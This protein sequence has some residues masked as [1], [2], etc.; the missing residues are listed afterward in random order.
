MA[1]FAL[2]ATAAESALGFPP[3]A[4]TKAYGGNRAEAVH[5]TLEADPVGVAILGL[6]ERHEE[7]FWEGTC[8]QLLHHFEQ[9]V[10][11]GVRKS[12]E[13]PKSPRALSSRLRRLVTFLRELR[14]LITFHARGTNG[15][16]IVTITRG[17]GYLTAPTAT[18]VTPPLGCSPDRSG[19][20][21]DASGGPG[22][23]VTDDAPGTK[24]P[25]PGLPDANSLEVRD[26]AGEVAVVT[27]VAVNFC[28][29]CGPV[30]WIWVGGA[31]ICPNCGEP[32]PKKA[33][34]SN[35]HIINKRRLAN[36]VE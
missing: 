27:V 31:R 16:R 1:D 15:Q 8:K 33:P 2:W 29:R 23:K 6:M 14:V 7:E 4:F 24:Q 30:E 13:W 9:H 17:K 35:P 3:G 32:P 18:P 36:D 21:E 19:T 5:E 34:C 12:H 20:P 28:T 10:E 11:E 22:S 25:P 26:H